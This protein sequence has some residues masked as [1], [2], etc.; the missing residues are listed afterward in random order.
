[1]RHQLK[2]A[3]NKEESRN[4]YGFLAILYHQELVAAAGRQEAIIHAG[5]TAPDIS[6]AGFR[7]LQNEFS[8][9]NAS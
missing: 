5:F 4:D 9:A 3:A 2:E 6:A 7:A 1:M 8:T